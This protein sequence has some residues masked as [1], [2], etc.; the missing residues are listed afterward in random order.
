M[1]IVHKVC[2]SLELHV[3]Q[4]RSHG[5]WESPLLNE[6]CNNKSMIIPIMTKA[7]SELSGWHWLYS[8]ERGRVIHKTRLAL[9]NHF[10]LKK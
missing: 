9:I 10:L 5:N 1:F 8:W 6:A 2:I 7:T 3:V 4:S